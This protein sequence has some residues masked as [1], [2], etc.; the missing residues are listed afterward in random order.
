MAKLLMI[1]RALPVLLACLLAR[2]AFASPTYPAIIQSELQLMQAPDC[3]LCHRDDL[4]G[5]GTVIRPFGRTLMG[6]F[7]LTGGNNIAALKAALAG[8]EA[9][10]SD[11][12]GDGVGDID[13][14]LMNT[15]PNVG[16]SGVETAPDVPL[17]ETGCALAHGAP[18]G[19]A[20]WGLTLAALS[21]FF[22][23]RRHS[24]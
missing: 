8:D 11:S 20:A 13:E 19:G 5:A 12:D 15:N 21:L 4:G 2:S 10:H 22:A 17:P 14:L 23:R 1:S 7:Q 9:Q 16:V 6:H 24:R 3:T 18:S